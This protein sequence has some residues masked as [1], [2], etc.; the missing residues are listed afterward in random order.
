MVRAV[1]AVEGL[2]DGLR[3]Y[4]L[5]A[6]MWVRS[7]MTYRA[8]FVMLAAGQFVSTG[9]DFAAILIMFAHTPRLGGFALPEVAFL[10]ATSGM[11]LGL[12]D[13]LIGSSGRLGQR[14]RDGSF[15]TLLVRPVPVFAQVAADRFALRRLGRIAQATV[16]LGWS[17]ASLDVHWTWDRVLMMPLMILSGTVIF[18][19]IFVLGAA[20]QFLASDAAEVQN[21]FIYGGNTLTQYPPTIF[22]RELVRG[23]TFLFPLAFVNWMPALYI[24]DRPDPLGLP[25]FFDFASPLAAALFCAVAALAWRAGLRGYRSTGS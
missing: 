4:V 20:F 14:V 24:L 3:A 22:A 15:D 17:L 12:A 16:V 6:G 21:A 1:R 10:Y 25:G 18:C 19:S 9:L 11:A 5:I 13:L 7:T 23:V 2:A 8:S